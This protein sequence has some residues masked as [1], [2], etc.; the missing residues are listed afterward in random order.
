M[1]VAMQ[2]EKDHGLGLCGDS[3]E[4]RREKLDMQPR[5]FVFYF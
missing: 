5:D 1:F 2:D 3:P 4:S